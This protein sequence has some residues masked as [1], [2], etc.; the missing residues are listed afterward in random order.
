MTLQNRSTCN[1]RRI[2]HIFEVTED[3]LCLQSM[4]FILSLSSKNQPKTNRGAK[5]AQLRTFV[6]SV[7]RQEIEDRINARNPEPKSETIFGIN[8]NG[9]KHV[10]N[11]LKI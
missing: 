4:I 10:N 2:S 8:I 5:N 1:F 3:I 7:L 11:E 6:I 9:T